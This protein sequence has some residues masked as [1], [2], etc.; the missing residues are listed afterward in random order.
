M[1]SRNSEKQSVELF[2]FHVFHLNTV[3]FLTIAN[4]RLRKKKNLYK[5]INYILQSCY[6]HKIQE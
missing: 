1:T 6:Q 5:I 4:T 3:T 2:K